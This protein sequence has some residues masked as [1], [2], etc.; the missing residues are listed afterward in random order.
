[1]PYA[2][3]CQDIK[4]SKAYPT[5]VD[6]WKHASENGLIVDVAS[7]EEH[8]APKRVLDNDYEIR[9]CKADATE[10]TRDPKATDYELPFPI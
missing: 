5:E 2:L 3:F 10:K 4:I 1:M 6:V 7:A 9:P 8:P